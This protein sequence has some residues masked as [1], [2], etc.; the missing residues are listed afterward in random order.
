MKE[1][2]D[3]GKAGT[4][5]A[6]KVV[7]G[8]LVWS[9]LRDTRRLPVA[10]DDGEVLAATQTLAGGRAGALQAALGVAGKAEA[11]RGEEVAQGTIAQT[12]TVESGLRATAA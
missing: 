6:E 5:V 2:N 8:V 12:G 4:H 3:R 10:I 9:A 7:V 11:V 1:R